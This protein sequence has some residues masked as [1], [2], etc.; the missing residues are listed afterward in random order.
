MWAGKIVK[1]GGTVYDVWYEAADCRST[2]TKVVKGWV[3]V[4]RVRKNPRP[5][6]ANEC[7]SES[8]GQLLKDSVLFW[9]RWVWR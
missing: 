4:N 9:N 2:E 8:R 7:I 1:S 5:A 3:L 6:R